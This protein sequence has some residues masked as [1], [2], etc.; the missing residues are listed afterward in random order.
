MNLRRQ[1]TKP[2]VLALVREKQI[3]DRANAN[4]QTQT[5]A[6]ALD[7]DIK[8]I[9]AQRRSTLSAGKTA[10]RL[11]LIGAGAK[12]AGQV[13]GFGRDYVSKYG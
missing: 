12:A 2:S 6:A 8:N 3:D 4:Y 7:T 13:Y 9:G 5:R 10:G 1:E 11:A